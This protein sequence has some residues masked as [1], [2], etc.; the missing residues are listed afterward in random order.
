MERR[1]QLL[2]L[3]Y[4]GNISAELFAEQEAS[5]TAQI[6]SLRSAPDP[7]PER[8]TADDLARRFDEVVELLAS[9]DLD[10]LWHAATDQERRTLI[11]ELLDCLEVHPDRL[12]VAIHGAPRLN[13]SLAEVGLGNGQSATVGVGGGT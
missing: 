11:E 1:R 5:L 2:E 10:R 12:T 3:H 4:A 13:V 6:N 9:L 8:E 7:E